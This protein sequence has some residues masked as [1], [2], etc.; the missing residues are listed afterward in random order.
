MSLATRLKR[1]KE[2]INES[3]QVELTRSRRKQGVQ[4]AAAEAGSFPLMTREPVVS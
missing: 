2:P 1:E 3:A 4:T